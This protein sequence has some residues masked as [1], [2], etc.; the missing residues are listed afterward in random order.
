M[1]IPRIRVYLYAAQTVA[2][3][4]AATYDGYRMDVWM[5]N[6]ITIRR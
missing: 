1:I 3:A 4:F 2:I 6:R 5:M